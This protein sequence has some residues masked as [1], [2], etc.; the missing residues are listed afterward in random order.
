LIAPVIWEALFILALVLANG[1]FA[2]AEIAIIAARRNRLQALSAQGDRAARI[3]LALAEDPNRF[4]PTVQVGI[5]LVSTFAAAFSGAHLADIL[6]AWLKTSS[7]SLVSR[8]AE[9]LA[10]GIVVVSLTV[11]SVLFGELVP[12]RLA[13]RQADRLARFAAYPMEFLARAGRPFVWALGK[14]TN[15]VLFLLGSRDSGD[16][17]VSVEDIE[18]MIETGTQHGV[19]QPAEQRVAL[20]ALRLGDR[21]ARDVMLPRTEIDA[22]DVSTPPEEV[23]GLMVMAGFSRLP[24]YEGN[25]DH[26][27]GFVHLK[28]VSKQQYLRLPIELRKLVHPP[29]FVPESVP[30]DRLLILFQQQRSHL[31]IVLDEYGGTEGMV[32]LQ[33]VLEELVGEIRDEHHRDTGH[34]MVRRNETSWL[35]DGQVPL[36]E[37]LEEI[38]RD[39]L[40]LPSPRG[41]T[42]LA[43]LVLAEMNKIPGVGDAFIWQGVHLEVVDMDGQ[44]IDRVLVSLKPVD[45]GETEPPRQMGE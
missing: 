2:G 4:L 17:S 14:A 23:L 36:E 42:T 7:L 22:V 40:E 19:L 15:A 18:H 20:E 6:A 43:G 35:V 24:V 3:A 21:T 41:Y 32:T 30:L 5:T 11:V 16:Q 38:G 9:P 39:D 13:L 44:R 8:Y 34:R 31:A 37:L 28:D 1:F 12:K 45:G 33:D 26:V 27:I 25:L 10:L 29:V